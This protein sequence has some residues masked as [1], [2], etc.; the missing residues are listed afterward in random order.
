MNRI[1]QITILAL[2]GFGFSALMPA[3][4]QQVGKDTPAALRA[5]PPMSNVRFDSGES[6]LRIPLEIDN[7]ILLLQVRVN[8]SRPL[9]FIFDTGASHSIIN[10]Q[11]AEE[12]GL[13]TQGEARGNATGGKIQG[14]YVKGV[15]LSVQGA[16]AS[17]QLIGS[18]A[19]PTIPGFEFDG[20]IGYGFIRQFVVEIDY[21]NKIMNLYDPQ[22]YRYSGKGDAMPLILAGRKIPL[23]RAKIVL[24]GRGPIEC[25]LEVDTG[26][27]GTFIINRPL[28]RKQGL[29][30]AIADSR[31]DTGRGAGGE[32]K[33]LVG[34]VKAMQFGQVTFDDPP[35]GVVQDTEGSGADEDN[36]GKIGGE[37]FRR[38]KMILDYSRRQM[39]LEPNNSLRDPYR[40]ESEAA[41]V[42]DPEEGKPGVIGCSVFRRL[43]MRREPDESFP[44]ID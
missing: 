13:K 6:S 20:V 37:I 26:A 12:L 2:S 34:R 4:A 16:E 31:P 39:I 10:S 32:E 33:R 1:I 38:F 5:Q 29:T 40:L 8:G 27:D 23:V 30:E 19:F 44:W 28:A 42:N 15:T 43:L 25:N 9:K 7:N 14:T 36:D 18:F 24:E 22:T 3:N 41:S 11:R 17:N 21:Q 35:V